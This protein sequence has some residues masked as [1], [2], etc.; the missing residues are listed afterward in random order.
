[1][2]GW[3]QLSATATV[4]GS[5]FLPVHVGNECVWYIQ[6]TLCTTHPPVG[7]TRFGRFGQTFTGK[8]KTLLVQERELP[9]SAGQL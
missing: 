7:Q 6:E 1:M 8:N 3:S 5:P 4:G 2:N 9:V